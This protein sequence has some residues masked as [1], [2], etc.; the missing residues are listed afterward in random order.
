MA[1]ALSNI[2]NNTNFALHLHSEA[3]ARLQEQAYTGSRINQSSD[4]PSDAYRILN[5]DAQK[6]NLNNYVSNVSEVI[7]TLEIST[8]II[9]GMQDL[10][11]NSIVEI[12]KITSGTYGE[13]GR[14][15]T[16]EG[17]DSMLEDMVSKANT[18]HAGKYIFGGGDTT[19]LPY[20]VQRTDGQITSVTY[21]G[22]SQ[23]RDIEA[24]PGV[25]VAAYY[26]GE[27]LF[28]SSDR[29]TPVFYGD[30][31]S[32]V[33]TGTSNV[34][35]DVWLTVA[36]DGG[37][38]YDLSVDGGTTTVNVAAAVVAGADITNIPVTNSAG[39]VLYV[40]AS[41]IDSEGTEL[42]RVSGTY[43]VFN[44]L[45]SIRDILENDQGLSETQLSP[46]YNNLSDPLEELKN[47]LASKQ[48]S[49][50]VRTG[51]LYKLRE[52][53]SDL[54]FNVEDQ[55]S[56]L[57]DADIAQI[58]IDISRRQVLYEMSLAIAGRLMSTSLLDYI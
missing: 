27:D 55:T 28:H 30:T 54:V 17:I 47:L 42:V 8:E 3:M 36:E 58:S 51:C 7:G 39:K 26:A 33:G 21:Q 2:Y 32:A 41:N 40:D 6:K 38:S 24:A 35:G 9:G 10:I 12:T 4:A 49:I 20:V 50:G 45:I 46:I 31:G 43:D 15:I 22:N 11:T 37:G 44:A 19:S 5:L 25:Q 13:A 48:S 52:N 18:Q 1:G 56:Q 16:A 23:S 14:N 29:G 34:R 57:Q 53:H